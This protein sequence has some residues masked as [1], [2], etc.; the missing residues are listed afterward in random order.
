MPTLDE[1]LGLDRFGGPAAR[2]Y[3][4][5]FQGNPFAGS[6]VSDDPFDTHASQLSPPT[7]PDISDPFNPPAPQL[8]GLPRARVGRN[9]PQP[10]PLSGGLPPGLS[11]ELAPQTAPAPDSPPK[12]DLGGDDVDGFKAALADRIQT[13]PREAV[14]KDPHG[15]L[16]YALD[17]IDLPRNT[18]ANLINTVVGAQP[19]SKETVFGM[20]RVGTG[21]MLRHLGLSFGDTTLG[22][23]GNFV[24]GFLGDVATD[25]LTYLTFGGAGLAKGAAERIGAHVFSPEGAAAVRKL[26]PTLQAAAEPIES[27]TH[28]GQAW[29]EKEARDAA[30]AAAADQIAQESPHLLNNSAIGV[31]TAGLK[32]FRPFGLP[33]DLASAGARFL[34]AGDAVNAADKAIAK[35]VPQILRTPFMHVPEASATLVD[36]PTFAQFL[37]NSRI[38]PAARAVWDSGPGIAAREMGREVRSWFDTTPQAPRNYPGMTDAQRLAEQQRYDSQTFGR[39]ADDYIAQQMNKAALDAPGEVEPLLDAVQKATGLPDEILNQIGGNLVER[40]YSQ[41]ENPADIAQDI[42]KLVTEADG[43]PE[44]A[45]ALARFTPS[46]GAVAKGP[47]DEFPTE[48]IPPGEIPPNDPTLSP[49]APAP[50]P[51]ALAAARAMPRTGP[52]AAPAASI[53][54]LAP[55]PRTPWTRETQALDDAVADAVKR[56][57][58]AGTDKPTPRQIKTQ[59][60][61]TLGNDENAAGDIVGAGINTGAA[62]DAVKYSLQRLGG[63]LRQD[64]AYALRQQLGDFVDKNFAH[65]SPAARKTAMRQSPTV[66][67]LRRQINQLNAR[68]S[69]EDVAQT[70]RDAKD[71]VAAGDLSDQTLIYAPIDTLPRPI[72]DSMRDEAQQLRDHLAEFGDKYSGRIRALDS[73]L[74]GRD[75]ITA[76]VRAEKTELIA[77]LRG[78]QQKM[79]IAEA[80]YGLPPRPADPL[81]S[82][83]ADNDDARRAA[84]LQNV[85]A[86]VENGT[87]NEVHQGAQQ[88]LAK[89]LGRE[90]TH[91]ETLDFLASWS[92]KPAS[93]DASAAAAETPQILQGIA[94]GEASAA[95]G[96][97]PQILQGIAPGE[98][99]AGETIPPTGETP[100]PE[101]PGMPAPPRPWTKQLG[102]PNNYTGS[103]RPGPPG[104]LTLA[105]EMRQLVDRFHQRAEERPAE[106]RPL[107]AYAPELTTQRDLGYLPRVMTGLP[108]DPMWAAFRRSSMPLRSRFQNM[109]DDILREKT[110]LE[111]NRS[112]ARVEEIAKDPEWRGAATDFSKLSDGDSAAIDAALRLQV[113]PGEQLPRF[114]T[115]LTALHTYREIEH[116]RTLGSAEFFKTLEERYGVPIVKGEPIP[117]GYTAPKFTDPKFKNVLKDVAFPDAVAREIEKH[118]AQWHDP[119][120]VLTAYR[121]YFMGPYKG[122]ALLSPG[123]HLGNVWG[124]VW[125][126]KLTDQYSPESQDAGLR[127]LASLAAANG[128]PSAGTAVK[129]TDYTY[130]QL[131]RELLTRNVIGRGFYAATSPGN[132][133]RVRELIETIQNPGSYGSA[134][135]ELKKG[136]VI[137]ANRE[138]G[139]MGENARRVGAV[140]HN[141]QNGLTL[142]EAV[143]KMKTALF[144]Y[145]D[146]TPVEAG[147]MNHPGLRDIF[148]FYT[149][150]RKNAELMY[151]MAFTN[152]SRLAAVPKLGLE[153]ESAFA[154]DQTLPP[155]LRP[156]HVR[157]E[158]GVQVSGGADPRFLNVA[159]MLP[160][161]E[162]RFNPLAPGQAVENVAEMIGGPARIAYELATNTDPY[163]DR[164][165][166]EYPGQQKQFLGVPMDPRLKHILR[167]IR[168]LNMIQQASTLA[169]SAESPATAAM[170]LAAYGAGARL[171]PVDVAR[172][173]HEQTA[174]IDQQLAAVRRD[175]KRRLTEVSDHNGDPSAD[176]EL[177]RLV[178]I[179]EQLRSQRDALPQAESRAIGAGLSTRRKKMLNDFLHAYHNPAA[180]SPAS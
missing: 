142:D 19:A 125:N 82:T 29:A 73:I 24:V 22:K 135:Q 117:A 58:A 147:G 5:L 23:I 122:I 50:N 60:V 75:E 12:F 99:S 157:R 133:D 171:F 118:V 179:H 26:A 56:L 87:P 76:P 54:E 170:D 148:P 150:T 109:R 177:A 180:P 114:D 132:I 66:Q 38:A 42:R 10:G 15:A 48:E 63:Q 18:I 97:T 126:M 136:N 40:F 166:L 43:T 55:T 94:P 70:T 78:D 64:Q 123:Y 59:I 161:G 67:Q 116:A 88:Y 121:R 127:V 17:I 11:D 107:G 98:A 80:D 20:P 178:G 110:V 165:I 31:T 169:G 134:W 130:G 37:E 159:R 173:V 45:E 74:A 176:P 51:D 175:L 65:M 9:L 13:I 57:R 25:P 16:Q 81:F 111:A 77:R 44:Q 124:D 103:P 155:S 144:D 146:L 34:G 32:E 128:A 2:R 105:D 62:S 91:D 4:S 139:S 1:L 143:A 30:L 106:I 79:S 151:R 108:S 172:Q 164:P 83:L 95:A 93:A 6:G 47:P 131:A 140:I 120:A 35:Y 89:A 168:P 39:W 69:V 92:G 84:N 138:I 174:R 8:P 160:V 137:A 86:D 21:D 68:E 102:G 90:P 100:P 149:W 129:G 7:Q 53:D 36:R 154:G 28:L 156:A 145:R 61:I 3:A 72:A 52:E 119:S 41:R 112:L 27:G 113:K 33:Y 104:E 14:E 163:F 162:M 152:P 115:D 167:N 46:R 85:L 153:A 71:A 96:E 158:G 141:L 101:T 49:L